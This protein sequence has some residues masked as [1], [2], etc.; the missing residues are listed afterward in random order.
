MERS[1]RTPLGVWWWRYYRGTGRGLPVTPDMPVRGARQPTSVTTRSVHQDAHV[2]QHQGRRLGHHAC[3]WRVAGV[4]TQRLRRL[5][6]SVPPPDGWHIE[7]AADTCL[8][9]RGSTGHGCC[10]HQEKSALM[11]CLGLLG[12]STSPS[13]LTVFPISS[14]LTVELF[15]GTVKDNFGACKCRCRQTVSRAVRLKRVV[16][17]LIPPVFDVATVPSRT[18]RSCRRCD[19]VNDAT[20]GVMAAGAAQAPVLPFDAVQPAD[21]VPMPVRRPPAT[22]RRPCTENRSDTP[23]CRA[24][25]RGTVLRAFRLPD[26]H[27]QCPQVHC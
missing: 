15:L 4:L 10:P 26:T 21:D 13:I 3:T 18:N 14:A 5:R 9:S 6:R 20:L 7:P 17:D 12:H 16:P 19:Q 24:S 22:R 2:R 25:T 1:T 8:R 11:R 23:A 27:G